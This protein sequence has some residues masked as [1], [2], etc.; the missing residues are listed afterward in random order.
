MVTSSVATE[1]AWQEPLDLRGQVAV[2]TGGS[3]GIGLAIAQALAERGCRLVLASRNVAKMREAAASIPGSRGFAP[4]DVRDRAAVEALF[5]DAVEHLGTV[6]ILV[7]CAG[8]GT[9]PSST[10]GGLDPVMGLEEVCWDD[11]VDT[12]LRGLFYSVRAAARVMVARRTGQIVNVSSARGAR[13]GQAYAAGYCASKM[14]GRAMLEAMAAELAPLGIRVMSLLPD[15]VDTSLIA[16][17]SL[18]PRG[19][20][21]P[22]DVGRFVAEM[23]SMPLDAT[24]DNPLL[25]PLG[26][27]GKMRRREEVSGDAR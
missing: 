9:S 6:D 7:A 27:R 5:D 19:A 25:S 10:R 15:A 8:I 11:V 21:Q 26:S 17:T 14:A 4:C 22:D 20:M 16:G 18:A 23:L 24:L 3:Q 1:T 12:N 2:I 13:R